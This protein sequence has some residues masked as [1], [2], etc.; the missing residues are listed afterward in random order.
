MYWKHV[1]QNVIY[2]AI[3]DDD[4]LIASS[5]IQLL[6]NEKAAFATKFDMHDLGEA[7][8][9]LGMKITRDRAARKLCINQERYILNMLVKFGMA[10]CKSISTPLEIGKYLEKNE[11]PSV[12]IKDYQAVTGSL[13]HVAIATK[14][15]IAAALRVVNQFASNP[16]E[17][18]WKAVKR[19]L[20]YLKGTK[21]FGIIF[22]GNGDRDVH[23][24][25][26][27]DADWAGDVNTRKSQS[28]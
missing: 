26:Y 18:H 2:L 8:F 3:Y 9:I 13:T 19:I 27:V 20:R 10:D 23:L 24:Y 7:S 1:Q 17:T 21:D 5:D 6:E 11:G 4:L 16:S 22:Y 14:P 12:K 15:D 25:G 28:G